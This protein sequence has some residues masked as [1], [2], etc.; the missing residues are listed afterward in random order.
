MKKFKISAVALSLLIF[1]VIF[2]GCGG[3]VQL[4]DYVH[5][6]SGGAVQVDVGEASG[7]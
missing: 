6:V 2:I 1:I 5:R 4:P 3:Q 7:G